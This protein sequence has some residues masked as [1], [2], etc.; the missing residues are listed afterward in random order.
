MVLRQV[1]VFQEYTAGQVQTVVQRCCSPRDN[2]QQKAGAHVRLIQTHTRLLLVPSGLRAHAAPPKL[3]K[4]TNSHVGL[5]FD[6]CY[7]ESEALCI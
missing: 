1:S 4:Q 5:W 2:L 7:E 3:G 6:C